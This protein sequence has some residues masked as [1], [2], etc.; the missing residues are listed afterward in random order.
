MEAA[1]RN[2]QNPSEHDRADSSTWPRMDQLR[3]VRKLLRQDS[4]KWTRGNDLGDGIKPG[5][6]QVHFS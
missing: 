4:S 1:H 5:K 2:Q 3:Q 6:L